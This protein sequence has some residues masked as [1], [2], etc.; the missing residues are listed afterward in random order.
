MVFL[1][2]S[3]MCGRRLS[4]FLNPMSFLSSSTVIVLVADSR[5]GG[6]S[7]GRICGGSWTRGVSEGKAVGILLLDGVLFL[8]ASLSST[9]AILPVLPKPLLLRSVVS[10][11]RRT[12]NAG[13]AIRSK[14]NC[15]ILS[16]I[17]TSNFFW[18]EF[19]N[20]TPVLLLP[21]SSQGQ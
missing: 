6:L 1:K 21:P 20:S 4:V 15:A 2:Q 12:L 11:V 5:S 13:R 7:R 9:V 18:L 16:P 14:I 17:L 3:L 10:R 8:G 19:T